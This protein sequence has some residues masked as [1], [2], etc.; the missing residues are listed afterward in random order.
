MKRSLTIFLIII[1]LGLCSCKTKNISFIN[2]GQMINYH[3]MSSKTAIKS[4]LSIPF[5]TNHKLNS[6][7][8]ITEL[9]GENTD[10]L[11]WSHANEMNPEIYSYEDYFIYNLQL[12]ID[13]SKSVNTTVNIESILVKV[14][15]ELF[16]I[17]P[18]EFTIESIPENIKEPEVEN[19]P[20]LIDGN[21]ALGYPDI[22]SIP[23]TISMD[24]YCNTTCNI[25]AFEYLD[26][27]QLSNFQINGRE[28]QNNDIQLEVNEKDRINLSFNV[29]LDKS[30]QTN[31]NL[32]AT[33]RIIYYTYN[34]QKMILV[35]DNLF[36]IGDLSFLQTC[37]NFIDSLGGK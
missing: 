31:T 11:T 14:N 25:K 13:T 18:N 10:K 15:E 23:E 2:T 19:Y 9:N 24:Y 28:V 36:R 8:T 21:L 4:A 22:K 26:F 35:D 5:I 3:I 29:C 32:I 34:N 37:K 7:P 27:I 30:L 1:L 12:L 17:S 20:F 33:N 6:V 16:T